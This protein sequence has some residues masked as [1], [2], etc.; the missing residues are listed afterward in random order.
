LARPSH[1]RPTKIPAPLPDRFLCELASSGGLALL[2]DYDGTLAELTTDPAQ[3]RP[4][5]GVPQMLAR[6]AHVQ[7]LSVAIITGRRIKEVQR[8]LGLS[9]DLFFS[10]VH[11][12]EFADSDGDTT[13]IPAATQCFPEL[14]EVRRWLTAHVL[15]NRGFWVEDKEA[16]IG[17]H[18]R[19]ADPVEARR[20]CDR[21]AEFIAHTTPGLQLMRLKKIDEAMPNIAGKNR[22]V[23]TA[24]ERL[25]HSHRAVYIGDDVTD[26]DAFAALRPDDVG[27][28]VGDVRASLAQ[29][30]LPNPQ[31]VA[32]QLTALDAF[33]SN[34]IAD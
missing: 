21:F 29:Y 2:L 17:L 27:I 25:P 28:V 14:D 12:L 4:I 20:L 23:T 5:P 11:G 34:R 7:S 31:S 16:A 22:A 3:A 33:L 1:S 19:S 18:Y 6:L 8:L 15:A 30:R 32:A 26:E 9:V 13:F 24:I 10:G